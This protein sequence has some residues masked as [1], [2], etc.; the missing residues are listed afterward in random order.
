MS[1]N[2]VSVKTISLLILGAAG[3]AVAWQNMKKWKQSR[4]VEFDA[5][6]E[7]P[8]PPMPVRKFVRRNSVSAECDISAADTPTEKVVYEKTPEERAIIEKVLRGNILFQSLESEHLN[9]VIDSM[10]PRRYMPGD[11]VIVQGTPGAPSDWSVCWH[12]CTS[13]WCV[14]GRGPWRVV[15]IG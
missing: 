6:D 15:M 14:S 13:C 8:E 5:K 9:E 11:K 2:L 4:K 12:C 1:D 10:H 7:E 3:V